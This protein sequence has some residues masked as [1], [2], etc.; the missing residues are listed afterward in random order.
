[1]IARAAGFTWGVVAALI[2]LTLFLLGPTLEFVGF[3]LSE[4]SSASLIYLAAFFVM[5]GRAADLAAAG[6]LVIVAFYTRLNNLPMVFAVAAFALPVTVPASALWQ[7]RAWRPLIRWPA[8][9]TIAGAL[10]LAVVLFAWRTWYYTGVFDVFY[11]TQREHLAVWK[12]G[13]S[14]AQAAAAM[15]SSVMMV[16]TA[17]DPPAFTWHGLP[18]L[19]AAAIALAALVGLP[20]FRRAPLAVVL[21]FVAG[22][23]GA[24]VTRGW[25]Y[26][27]RFSIHLFGAASVLCTW[28]AAS[29]IRAFMKP[30]T[31]SSSATNT[32]QLIWRRRPSH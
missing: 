14:I 9:F 23:A 13:M 26:E 19:V 31:S 17:A 5:R 3:G 16:L 25:A 29:A 12:P 30:W 32:K 15:A 24:L 2:P 28:A 6:I 21:L 11:G 8:V 1:V 27:G 7:P 18:V 4:I 10:A 20:G 22:V